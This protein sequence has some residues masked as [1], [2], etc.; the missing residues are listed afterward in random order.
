MHHD[1]HNNPN[2]IIIEDLEKAAKAANMTVKD[3]AENIA[4]A[5]GLS[6]QKSS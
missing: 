4:D 5:V 6:C 1:R 3:A 2:L